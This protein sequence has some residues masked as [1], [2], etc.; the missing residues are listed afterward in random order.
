MQSKPEEYFHRKL[1]EI[2]IQQK[3]FVNTTTVSYRITHTI[4]ETAVLSA[5]VDMVQTMIGEERAHEIR[6]TP[7][8]RNGLSTDC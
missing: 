7:L 8:S 3:S 6:N 2:R 4:T 5:E 1:D